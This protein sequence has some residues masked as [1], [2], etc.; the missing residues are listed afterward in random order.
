LRGRRSAF[1]PDHRSEPQTDQR[2]GQPGLGEKLQVI[3]FRLTIKE[4]H[5][6]RPLIVRKNLGPAAEADTENR[7]FGN[8]P[9]RVAPRGRLQAQAVAAQ[10][11][12][13]DPASGL[14]AAARSNH[15]QHQQQEDHEARQ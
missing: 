10:D 2:T 15:E 8:H 4:L 3:V 7:K 9:Q 12:R 1:T 13:A 14:V 5:R 11:R 6:R